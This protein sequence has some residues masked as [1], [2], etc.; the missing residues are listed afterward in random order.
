MIRIAVTGAKGQVATAPS[1][2]ARGQR[3]ARVKRIATA[4]SHARTATGQL[5]PE[6]EKLRIAYGV[7]LPCWQTSLAACCARLVQ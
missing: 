4:D 2:P 3:S 5:A 7:A 1:R 6:N